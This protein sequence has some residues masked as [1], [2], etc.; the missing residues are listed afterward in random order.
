MSIDV[1]GNQEVCPIGYL[2]CF[3]ERCCYGLREVQSTA[4]DTLETFSIWVLCISAVWSV[5]ASI[6]LYYLIRALKKGKLQ[7]NDNATTQLMSQGPEGST[8]DSNIEMTNTEQAKMNLND[9]RLKVY[10]L[11]SL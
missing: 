10:P 5:I 2:C 8:D 1:C 6:P 9:V 7:Q 4:G 11:K 3:K